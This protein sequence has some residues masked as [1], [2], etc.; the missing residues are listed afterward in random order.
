MAIVIGHPNLESAKTTT[1]LTTQQDY[2]KNKA[3][4]IKFY[5]DTSIVTNDVG[6]VGYKFTK[7]F[8]GELLIFV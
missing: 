6:D 5:W 7:D 2:F 8:D 1:S 4:F 3:L